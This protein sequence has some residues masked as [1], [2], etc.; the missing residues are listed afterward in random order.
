MK[1]SSELH[2]MHLFTETQVKYGGISGAYFE[3]SGSQVARG[4][5]ASPAWKTTVETQW[6]SGGVAPDKI[7]LAMPSSLENMR[8]IYFITSIYVDTSGKKTSQAG[9][10]VTASSFIQRKSKQKSALYT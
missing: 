9:S 10:F 6:G 2:G 4:L 7:V 5:G 8:N 3:L 1:I